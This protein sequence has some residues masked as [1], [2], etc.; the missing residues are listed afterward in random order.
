MAKPVWVDADL[1]VEL[2][3][4][5]I[6]LSGGARGVRD[7][8]L[9]ESALARPP[10]LYTYEG[11]DD[12]ILLAATYAAAVSANHA[13]ID[14][15]KRAAFVCMGQFLLDNGLDL[16]ADPSEAADVFLAL[17]AGD[18]TI[19]QLVEWLRRNVQAG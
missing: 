19:D 9:L 10:N 8:G 7:L 12:L 6:D 17:A 11:V 18:L 15:N 14:G 16:S 2:H 5:V 13:F 1:L 3:E 4:E